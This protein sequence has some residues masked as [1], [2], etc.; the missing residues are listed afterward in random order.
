MSTRCRPLPPPV[1]V[2]NIYAHP[3]Q[4]VACLLVKHLALEAGELAEHLKRNFLGKLDTLPEHII[5]Y[6]R[7]A[8]CSAVSGSI[9]N[10][11]MP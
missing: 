8:H 4:L 1:A 9:M 10:G 2:V 6:Q 11:A 5:L 7:N 3:P